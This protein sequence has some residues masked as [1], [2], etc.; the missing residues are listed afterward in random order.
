MVKQLCRT[1]IHFDKK[2]RRCVNGQIINPNEKVES[3]GIYNK[4]VED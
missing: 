1:C 4:E 3:C 2:S